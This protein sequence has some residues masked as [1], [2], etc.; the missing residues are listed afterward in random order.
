[1]KGYCTGVGASSTW[2]T[3]VGSNDIRVMTRNGVD[4]P[5]RDPSLVLSAATSLWLPVPPKR[6]FDFLRD[7]NSRSQVCMYLCIQEYEFVH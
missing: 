7:A 6:V 3:L 5:G 4:E 2:S 1:M